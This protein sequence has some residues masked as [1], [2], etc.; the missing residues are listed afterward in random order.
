[1]PGTPAVCTSP[2]RWLWVSIRPGQDGEAAEV[3]DFGVVGRPVVRSRDGLDPRVAH[4]EGP[5]ADEP[6]GLDVQK[7]P[8]RIARGRVVSANGAGLGIV[9]SPAPPVARVAR[10]HTMRP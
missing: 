8:A 3:D 4:E 9:E 7:F 6:P 5:R 1:M 2:T 10:T